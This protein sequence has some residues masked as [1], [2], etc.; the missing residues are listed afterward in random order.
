MALVQCYTSRRRRNRTAEQASA[1]RHRS[2]VDGVS[3]GSA[4]WAAPLL[5]GGV[6]AAEPD[7][8][9]VVPAFLLLVGL[10]FLAGLA[11]GMTVEHVNLRTRQRQLARDR[12]A[13]AA[14]ARGLRQQ[15]DRFHRLR[16]EA[17]DG[18]ALPECM[19]L[20]G[21]QHLP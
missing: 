18:E 16:D 13:L 5:V 7:S 3:S 10:G 14:Q 15:L 2:V 8:V 11:V 12:R 9:A 17:T 4:T 1:G 20:N 6:P 21:D 19:P